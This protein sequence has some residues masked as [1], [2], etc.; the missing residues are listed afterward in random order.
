M[1]G[2]CQDDTLAN[3]R[4][5]RASAQSLICQLDTFVTGK[6][7]YPAMDIEALCELCRQISQMCG[8]ATYLIAQGLE[9][10]IKS[11]P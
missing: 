7:Q 2:T 4:D 1:S 11:P 5:A 9:N 10:E 3:I 6:E 8:E